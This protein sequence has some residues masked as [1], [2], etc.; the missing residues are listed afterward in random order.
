[1]LPDRIIVQ[2]STREIER[3]ADDLAK[4]IQGLTESQLWQKPNHIP[5]SVGTLTRHLTGNLNH[6]IGAG[7]LE[8]GYQRQRDLEFTQSGLSKEQI[9][10][11]LR[12]SVE[13]ALQGSQQVT[14]E[15]LQQRPY[16]SPDGQEFVSL[17]YHAVRLATHF[18]LHCGQADY[19]C[20]ILAQP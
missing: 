3:Y 19:A 15:Q 1:M 9:L 17:A 20:T 6:Y 12:Q 16:H 18:A 13:I 2:L 8:N 10:N 4:L 5:N 11:D 14:D 7:I